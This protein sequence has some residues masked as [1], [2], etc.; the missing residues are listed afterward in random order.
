[1]LNPDSA[2]TETGLP[3][4]YSTEQETLSAGAFD[5]QPEFKYNIIGEKR[6]A[7]KE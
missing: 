7:R 4:R 1:M 2:K 3:A 6:G 5:C